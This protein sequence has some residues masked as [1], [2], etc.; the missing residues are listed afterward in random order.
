M[1]RQKNELRKRKRP[2]AVLPRA[3]RVHS[4]A[5]TWLSLVEL[6]RSRAQLRFARHRKPIMQKANRV[7]YQ[8]KAPTGNCIDRR[9][10]LPAK[11]AHRPLQGMAPAQLLRPNLQT[12]NFEAIT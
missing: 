3:V 12:G 6:L 11:G 5:L 10:R 1:A 2:E 8:P 7:P 4:P 9:D